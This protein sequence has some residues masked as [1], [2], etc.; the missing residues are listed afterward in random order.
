MKGN[1]VIVRSSGETTKIELP[2][3]PTLDALKNAIGGGHLE[4]VPGFT[5]IK[6]DGVEHQCAAFCDEEGKLEHR[7]LPVNNSATMHWNR[8]LRRSGGGGLLGKDGL[9]IDVLVGDIAIVFGDQEF[10]A[11]L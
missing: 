7:K 11:A 10:M 8:A 6:I 5:T 4:L 1:I 3:E 9:P 2:G